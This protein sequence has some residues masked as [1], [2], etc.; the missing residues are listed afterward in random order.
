MIDRKL[1]LTIARHCRALLKTMLG[2]INAVDS[3]GVL[4]YQRSDAATQLVFIAVPVLALFKT[5]AAMIYGLNR[6]GR[7]ED[8]VC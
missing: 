3:T 2:P 4:R 8:C 5:L 1:L 6:M 7:S